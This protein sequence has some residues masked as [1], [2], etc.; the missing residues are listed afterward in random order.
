MA[1]RDIAGACN[2]KQ[3]DFIENYNGNLVCIS[4]QGSSPCYSTYAGGFDLPYCVGKKRGV[5]K[6]FKEDDKILFSLCMVSVCAFI[7][8]FFV[9]LPRLRRG[10]R[11][12]TIQLARRPSPSSDFR[13]EA[14]LEVESTPLTMGPSKHSS[15][16]GRRGQQQFRGQ[17]LASV[18]TTNS[19][20][21]PTGL[22]EVRHAA[23][24][25]PLVTPAVVK[26][27]VEERMDDWEVTERLRRGDS[28]C[29]WSEP[30]ANDFEVR[31]V[32]YLS[33]K[34]KIASK[35]PLFSIV[36]VNAFYS[37]SSTEHVAS[38]CTS[39][40]SYL[41]K[42]SGKDFFIINWMLP[43]NKCT[44][45]LFARNEAVQDSIAGELYKQFITPGAANDNFRKT[46]LK[47]KAIVK[48]APWVI[49]NTAQLLGAERPAILGGNLK[50]H[51]FYG[52][53]YMEVDIDITTSTIARK[54]SGHL[55]SQVA[56]VVIDQVHRRSIR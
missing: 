32:N 49:K 12:D 38:K 35:A 5:L 23:P 51:Y 15:T 40:A 41:Q 10:W 3:C 55:L 21:D 26:Q 6:K 44:V 17:Y 53:N 11:K 54:I 50:Q 33:D 47:Y 9:W 2:A 39:L 37:T 56:A 14:V 22:R 7:I 43:G 20:I 42:Q 46:R 36:G 25:L 1:S 13:E 48:A 16:P 45:Y 24:V 30:P 18:S 29:S 27:A 19:T 52:G 4:G 8:G 34:K 28:K 31:D